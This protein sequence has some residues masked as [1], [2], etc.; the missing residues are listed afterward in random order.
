MAIGLRLLY[1][2]P[3]RLIVLSDIHAN[4]MALHAVLS[5]VKH[6]APDQVVVAGDVINRGPHSLACWS[7]IQEQRRTQGWQVIKGNHEDYVL[8]A[9]ATPHLVQA[10]EHEFFAHTRWTVE[11]VRPALPDLQALP[12][13]LSLTDPAGGEIRFL[14]ASMQGNRCGLYEDMEDEHLASLVA[15][16]PRVLVAG[17]T[18]IPF[19]RQVGATLVVNAGSA[20]LPF[21]GDPRVSLAVLDWKAGHWQARIERVAYDR[22]AAERD[23]VSTGYLAD[24][25]P[26]IP[27]ILDELRH[28]RPR[29]GQWHRTF[30]AEVRAGKYTVKESVDLLLKNH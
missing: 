28:A 7:L 25:G 13:Q 29:L 10:W 11:Q 9:A 18:H 5:A 26:M 19:V 17:H 6:L 1:I 21:D 14:H 3:M 2:S 8:H 24:G 30:E 22:S 27:L 16:A 23:F 4:R 15:P 12:D 20:G